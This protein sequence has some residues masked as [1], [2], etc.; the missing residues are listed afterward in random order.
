MSDLFAI[1]L[2]I[3]GAAL[4]VGLFRPSWVRQSS[5]KRIAL[6]YG[7][8][9]IIF[10][11][12]IAVTAPHSAEPKTTA[13]DVSTASATTS[14]VQSVATTSPAIVAQDAD[15]D[16]SSPSDDAVALAALAKPPTN[17]EPAAVVS[18]KKAGAA[19]MYPNPT[20]TPGAALTTDASK[21]CAS[22]YASS[23]RSVSSATKKQV[24]A[25]YGVSYPQPTGAY[26]VDHFIPLEI[27]GSN[28]I[29][30]LW[31]EPAAPTPGFHQK[32]QFEDFEHAEICKGIIS[33]QEAQNRMVSDW[34]A[35][36]LLEIGSTTS[37][38]TS[39]QTVAPAPAPQSS[40]PPSAASSTAAYYTSSYGSSKYY[41]PANCSA[42]Q[43]LSKSYLVSFA[44]LQALLA[45]YPNQTLSPQC[46]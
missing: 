45:K 28:D 35:Y 44:S 32:D 36:W 19:Y 3:S 10:F 8:A 23:V 14:D 41:Y 26:E 12:L 40:T 15:D 31:L 9:F 17:A 21:I 27:G 25:E 29:K 1:L 4:L 5:R 20:L 46:Q 22:G 16:I 18:G 30:N 2:L 38:P 13:S 7:S 33:V 42:W 34:Y 6:I 37:A 11:I 43:G 24:Y 39:A